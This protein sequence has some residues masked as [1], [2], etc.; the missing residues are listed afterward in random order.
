MSRQLIPSNLTAYVVNAHTLSL[1][2]D[3]PSN[4]NAIDRVYIVATELGPKNR[5][6]QS[7]SFDNSIKKLDFQINP[8]DPHSKRTF[9]ILVLL[10]SSSRY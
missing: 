4:V 9:Y 3:L 8:N 1:T 7:Q 2:W 6:I 5:T 10:I